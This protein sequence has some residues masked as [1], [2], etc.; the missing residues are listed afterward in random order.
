MIAEGISAL[1]QTVEILVPYSKGAVLDLLHRKAQ[2]AS[3]EYTAE[4]TLI[5]CSMDQLLYA[6]VV[7]EL[8][9]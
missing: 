5:K 2:I 4:G 7:K 6:R 1:R 8:K 9:E 3:E